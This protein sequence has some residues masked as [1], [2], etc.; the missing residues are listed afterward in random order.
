MIRGC[1]EMFFDFFKRK[2][3]VIEVD[4]DGRPSGINGKSRLLVILIIA[5]IVVL[6][7]GG[8]GGEKEKK[9]SVIKE[10][11]LD[12]EIETEQRLEEM[13]SSIKGAGKVNAMV[14]FD[15]GKEKVLASD[16][17][18]QLETEVGED[19]NTNHSSDE[20]SV[21]IVGSGADEK[22]FVL[23]EK[24]PV[25][26]GVFIT[27]TGGGNETVK[28]EIYEAVKALFGISGHRIKVS[29]SKN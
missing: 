28:L 2:A 19:A 4:S 14:V 15:G 17:K 9:E 20:E 8:F 16:R 11:I 10:N 1:L 29:A 22:P 27:A 25:P 24:L 13:L 21:L 26:S 23:K 6:A 18:S 3:K 12:Y 7:F 5:A